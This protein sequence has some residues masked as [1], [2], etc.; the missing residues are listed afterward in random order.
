V[1]LIRSSSY[2]VRLEVDEEEQLK[3]VIKSD[4]VLLFSQEKDPSSQDS[5]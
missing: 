4:R 3:A 2:V 5:G 1:L